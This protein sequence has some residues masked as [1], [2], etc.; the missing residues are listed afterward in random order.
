VDEAREGKTRTSIL[1]VEDDA[2]ALE[3]ATRLVALEFPHAA[4]YS[5][6]DGVM[7]L[8]Q[9]NDHHPDIVITD[10]GLPLKNGIEMAREMKLVRPETKF[11][12][13]SAYNEKDLLEQFKQIGIN[14][15]LLKPLNFG[16]LT[17]AIARCI[18]EIASDRTR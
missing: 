9:F 1:I 15:Y 4:I 7:G 6:V 2:A 5:A 8:E 13:L 14:S 17:A 18:A 16:H 10:I 11:I 3:I 12:V